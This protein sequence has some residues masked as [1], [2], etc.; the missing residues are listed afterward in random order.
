MYKF[1]DF[2]DSPLGDCGAP[3]TVVA[4]LAIVS[5]LRKTPNG[6]DNVDKLRGLFGMEGQDLIFGGAQ[7]HKRLLITYGE[8]ANQ[9]LVRNCSPHNCPV[10]LN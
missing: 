4:L 7:S 8:N 2:V 1:W 10:N 6:E 5:M 3:K 9:W